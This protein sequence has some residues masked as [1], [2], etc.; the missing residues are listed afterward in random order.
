[1]EDNNIQ[2]S[3]CNS[4]YASIR[5]MEKLDEV[6]GRRFPFYPRTVIQAIYDGRTGAPLEA[7]LAQYNNIYVQYQGTAVRT[8]NIVPKEMR[9]KGIII[10]YVDMQGN[11]I[12]EKCV[13]DA[14][15]DNFH[16]GLDVNWV[17]V[18]ELT[19]SGDISVSVKGTWV[20]NGEDTGIAALGPKG[21]N[22]LTPWLKTIDNKLHF[23]YDNET[24]EKCSD[25]IAA[26][27]RFQDNKFQISRDNKT[28]SDLSGEVTNSLYIKA[29]VT[30][31]SQYP[32]PKQGDMIMVG[33]T[34]ADDDAEHAK[35]IYHLNI[36][37]AEGWVD[38]G[39][40]Q[41]IN[42]GV[43]QELGD[44]ETEVMSQKA[45]SKKFSEFEE[46][47]KYFSLVNGESIQYELIEGKYINN[48]GIEKELSNYSYAVIS[49]LTNIIGINVF[50]TTGAD[51]P[52]IIWLD[53]NNKII[54]KVITNQSNSSSYVQSLKPFNSTKCIVNAYGTDNL[55]I[56][57]IGRAHV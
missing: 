48:D 47:Y 41:S 34:Y 1:M 49:E 13:N 56:K 10:S 40:F 33:P 45:V 18:D 20:I 26:Y 52:F 3:C 17:R 11:A 29:Y 42:V 14:Q 55:I 4:K 51:A 28:W 27:F 24:W 35:P 46:Q 15:R 50:T 22:G 37:N 2:D 44:S 21:D 31:K 16:W 5:Q 39:P 7:I 36:Y 8:R 9:R 23:S 12:T 19:F 54:H 25:Y 6:S 38:N 32:N 53:S 30:D 57:K 43:V